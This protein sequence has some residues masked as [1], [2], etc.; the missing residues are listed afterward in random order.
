[1]CSVC[2]IRTWCHKLGDSDF[3]GKDS[4]L[5]TII[6]K[7]LVYRRHEHI[8]RKWVCVN[9]VCPHPNAA[10]D[11]THGG[12]VLSVCPIRAAVYYAQEAKYCNVP[13]DLIKATLEWRA[14]GRTMHSLVSSVL[15]EAP[16]HVLCKVMQKQLPWSREYVT[17]QI[18]LLEATCSHT[19]SAGKLYNMDNTVH[20]LADLIR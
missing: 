12:G 14:V 4:N 10:V 13:A 3:T 19:D 18:G 2:M 15:I 16:R 7:N 20:A 17:E 8:A 5:S 1:M 11:D 9:P 6:A